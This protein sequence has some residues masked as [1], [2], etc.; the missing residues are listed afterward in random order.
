MSDSLKPVPK[1]QAAINW[2]AFATIVVTGIAVFYPETYSALPPG[3]EL[4]LGTFIGSAVAT[5]AGYIKR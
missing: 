1:V 3:F 5:G 2:G 4:A